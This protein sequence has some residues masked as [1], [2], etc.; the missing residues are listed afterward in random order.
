MARRHLPIYVLFRKADMD[1]NINAVN[2][3][4]ECE[5]DNTTG[6]NNMTNDGHEIEGELARVAAVLGDEEIIY[7]GWRIEWRGYKSNKTTNNCPG[8]CRICGDDICIDEEIWLEREGS[9]Y[10]HWSCYGMEEVFNGLWL[11]HSISQGSILPALRV[12]IP[13]FCGFGDIDRSGLIEEPQIT[14][15]TPECE[16]DKLKDDGYIRMVSLIDKANDITKETL[17]NIKREALIKASYIYRI[18]VTEKK[19]EYDL[20]VFMIN[21]IKYY[22]LEALT[23]QYISM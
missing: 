15:N 21:A 18:H 23:N 11:A 20:E 14:C 22:W 7:H 2:K 6:Y 8:Y 13:G 3:N 19:K 4:Q 17:N 1:N 10:M 5:C 16:L 9:D 12:T